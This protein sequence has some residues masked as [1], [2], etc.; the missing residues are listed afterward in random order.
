[1]ATAQAPNRDRVPRSDSRRLGMT[2]LD[3]L[4]AENKELRE[5][6]VRLSEIVVRNVLDRKPDGLAPRPV[7]AAD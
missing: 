7:A 2:E 6:V 3:A 5:L 4:Q 1:M